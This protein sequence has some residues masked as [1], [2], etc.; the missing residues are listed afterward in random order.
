MLGALPLAG[1]SWEDGAGKASCSTGL[2]PVACFTRVKCGPINAQLF[3]RDNN[4]LVGRSSVPGVSLFLLNRWKREK[5]LL[6]SSG[7]AS[8][9]TRVLIH[10]PLPGS[11]SVR[12]AE[13]PGFPLLAFF[14]FLRPS[15]KPLADVPSPLEP[16]RLLSGPY[17]QGWLLPIRRASR[18]SVSAPLC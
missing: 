2:N 7:D 3:M 17:N 1:L 12:S 10:L 6:V 11:A 18:I 14:A 16:Q 8:S 15:C 13:E 9:L 4:V 5:P